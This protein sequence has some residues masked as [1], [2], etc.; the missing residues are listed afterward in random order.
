MDRFA[1]LSRKLAPDYT[2]YFEPLNQDSTKPLAQAYL[3]ESRLFEADKGTLAPFTI[4]A[5][6]EALIKSGRVPGRF[7]TLLNNVIERA[8]HEK[9]EIINVEQ[10]RNVTRVRKPQE[11][12]EKDFSDRLPQA[13]IISED[14]N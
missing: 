1:A 6:D 7:L 9:W 12:N 10:I 3:D 11:A 4:D 14:E 5:L 2:V 8:I 13:I